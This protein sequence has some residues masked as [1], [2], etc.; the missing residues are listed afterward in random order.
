MRKKL[1]LQVADIVDTS[2]PTSLMATDIVDKLIADKY[3]KVDGLHRLPGKLIRRVTGKGRGYAVPT[4]NTYIA[5]IKAVLDERF[6]FAFKKRAISSRYRVVWKDADRYEGYAQLFYKKKFLR[7]LKSNQEL[8]HGHPYEDNIQTDQMS[9][10]N[11]H[12]WS[13]IYD[14]V[15][16]DVLAEVKPFWRYPFLEDEATKELKEILL[17]AIRHATADFVYEVTKKIRYQ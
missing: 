9:D 14:T 3:V 13:A 16:P 17:Y 12:V 1:I 7:A 4:R 6:D 10:G 11:N 5:A 15:L 2:W 8:Y